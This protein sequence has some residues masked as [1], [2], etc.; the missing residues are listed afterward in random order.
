[1]GNTVNTALI[2]LAVAG[3]VTALH[4]LSLKLITQVLADLMVKIVQANAIG[5]P[6]VAQFF[7]IQRP[8]HPQSAVVAGPAGVSTEEPGLPPMEQ[9]ISRMA[10]Y[11]EDQFRQ[12]GHPIGR[13]EA[14]EQARIM[15][16][17]SGV[18]G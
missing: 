8:G 13:G 1:M 16:A 17:D 12:Q 2:V 4:Y 9:T 7:P 3:G 6:P 14:M 5:G 18:M 15:M 11:L 10:D